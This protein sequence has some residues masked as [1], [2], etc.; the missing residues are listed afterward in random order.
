MS[1]THSTTIVSGSATPVTAYGSG[2]TLSPQHRLTDQDVLNLPSDVHRLCTV[3]VNCYFIGTP[4]ERD[5][6]LV[7]AGIPMHGGKIAGMA[8]ELFGDAPPRCIVLTH[9]HFDHVGSLAALLKLWPGVTV[10]AHELELPYITGGSDYPPPDPTVGG[11][12]M[13]R[14]AP[15]FPKHSYDFR[16][17]I[18]VLPADGSIPHLPLWR[19]IATPGHTNGHISL[20]RESDST[21]IVG[22]A[23]INQ[24]QESL[25]GVITA[26]PVM[27]GPPT[28]F[29]TDWRLAADS[30][31]RLALL[32]PKTAFSGHGVPMINP[33]LAHDLRWLTENFEQVAVPADGRYVRQPALADE[34][35]VFS[36]PPK[37][38]DSRPMIIAAAA[39]AAIVVGIATWLGVK[40]KRR[41]RA[42]KLE[43]AAQEA[44]EERERAVYEVPV[45]CR[46]RE[47][48]RR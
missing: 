6:V 20:W 18:S 11:G 35:G 28:Y 31:R 19:W 7:D 23:F 14:S 38:Q 26:K 3:L 9:G 37:V 44:F 8:K 10:Y 24:K 25:I 45:V 13:A 27:H 5:W 33:R 21:L 46:V 42:E 15:L 1:A 22:D 16:P 34:Q 41:G 43:A 32:H 39:G 30:V 47:V 12:L 40:A 29:T 2:A 17:N 4:G 36:I 48:Q